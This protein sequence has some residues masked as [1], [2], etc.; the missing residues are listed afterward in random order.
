MSRTNAIVCYFAQ[1]NCHIYLPPYIYENYIIKELCA[2]ESSFCPPQKSK[3]ESCFHQLILIGLK[4]QYS[5]VKGWY[6][7]Q[8]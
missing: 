4:E 2:L 7:F 6:L 5:S 3:N 8:F 1:E